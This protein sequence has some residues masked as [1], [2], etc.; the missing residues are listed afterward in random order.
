MNRINAAL[1]AV[2]ILMDRAAA[3]DDDNAVRMYFRAHWSV[4][5]LENRLPL[6]YPDHV[7]GRKLTEGAAILDEVDA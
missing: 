6:T 1:E 3:R 7:W 5:R 2:N 4:M